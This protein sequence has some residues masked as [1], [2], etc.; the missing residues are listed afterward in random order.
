MINIV[1]P[2]KQSNH[3]SFAEV[4]LCLFVNGIKS[5]AVNINIS[6]QYK[7]TTVHWKTHE[8]RLLD[9]GDIRKT[10]TATSVMLLMQG[11]HESER[12][13]WGTISKLPAK[14]WSQT[15]LRNW[16]GPKRAEL[17]QQTWMA[18]KSKTSETFKSKTS[19]TLF[20]HRKLWIEIFTGG[21][22]KI[23]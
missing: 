15:L 21:A 7:V 10:T 8:V 16:G 19:E 22:L 6:L 17:F 2:F 23:T 1:L 18:F 4:L 14:C 3:A 12:W 11:W 20:Y 9:I 13:D 5:I